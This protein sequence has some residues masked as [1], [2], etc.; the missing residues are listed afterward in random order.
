MYVVLSPFW[1]IF[2]TES[3]TLQKDFLQLLIILGP[4]LA[5][6]GHQDFSSKIAFYHFSSPNAL[7]I[8]V[9]IQ[10]NLIDLLPVNL[11]LA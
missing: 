5:R 1:L 2:V 11:A 3:F 8:H 4:L 10:K 7:E 9:H 6:M